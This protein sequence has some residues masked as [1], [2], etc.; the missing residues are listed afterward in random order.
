MP[1][2]IHQSLFV[3][4]G[5]TVFIFHMLILMAMVL[6]GLQFSREKPNSILSGELIELESAV[7][8]TVVVH[9]LSVQKQIPQAPEPIKQAFLD[10]LDRVSETSNHSAAALILMSST[11]S[12]ILNNPEPPY[13]ISSRE[14][15]E[16]GRVLLNACVTQEGG[17]YSLELSKT[18]GYPA[19]DRSALNTVRLW[20]FNPAMR[21]H[22]P[23][24]AC[25]RLPIN[26]V[27]SY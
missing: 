11:D 3:R 24:P 17:I 16:Q 2:F 20:K 18:S 4:I 15:G 6:F 26:F 23:N 10:E 27:L 14:N 25:Y 21:N 9:R 22:Q 8:S 1:K 5:F 12:I 13:P 7:I 19:L